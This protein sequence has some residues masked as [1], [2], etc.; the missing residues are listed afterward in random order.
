MNEKLAQTKKEGR[1][2]LANLQ[3][4]AK[5]LVTAVIFTMGLSTFGA[6][7]QIVIHD[8][9]PTFFTGGNTNHQ[10]KSGAAFESEITDKSVSERGDLFADM[11]VEEKAVEKTQ[12]FY[13]TDKFVWV[14]KW[15]HIHLFGMNMIFIFMG[16]ISYCLNLSEKL[17]T[18]LIV[19]PFAGIFIDIA[20]MWL[21][22][23]ISP[24]FF[25]LHIPGGNL[26]VTVFVIVSVRAL[27]EMWIIQKL[28]PE[29]I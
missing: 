8:I 19:L 17:R 22:A 29:N 12:S 4:P 25:W 9:I 13:K 15:T 18:W 26:F 20:A 7:G 2:L 14:L 16:M 5:A 21:K 6:M 24:V 28:P 27:W 3:I 11:V 23:F 1:L 10:S